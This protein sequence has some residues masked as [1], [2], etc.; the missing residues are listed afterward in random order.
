[1]P[2]KFVYQIFQISS[3]CFSQFKQFAF[4]TPKYNLFLFLIVMYIGL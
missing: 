1:M 4:D 2:E 3:F